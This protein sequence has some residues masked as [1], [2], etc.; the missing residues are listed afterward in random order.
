M[1][2]PC[3]ANQSS[4]AGV[5]RLR[6][7]MVLLLSVTAGD[8]CAAGMLSLCGALLLAVSL[9]A[10]IQEASVAN[11]GATIDIGT[12]GSSGSTIAA[13]DASSGDGV[14]SAGSSVKRPVSAGGNSMDGKTAAATG[15]SAVSGLGR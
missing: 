8:G 11:G 15:C 5:L 14:E 13:T 3:A 7:S 10:L 1:N 2:L 9:A 4:L 6:R 12:T